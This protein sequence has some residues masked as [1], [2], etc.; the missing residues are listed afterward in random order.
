LNDNNENKNNNT[1][2]YTGDLVFDV[3]GD[4]ESSIKKN[5]L[6]TKWDRKRKKFVRTN[7]GVDINSHKA[8][9]MK[10]ESGATIKSKEPRGKLYADWKEKNK[11]EIPKQG[12]KE[13]VALTQ[14]IKENNPQ[15]NRRRKGI[16]HKQGQNKGEDKKPVKSELKTKEQIHKMR[17]QK[18]KLKLK[19]NPAL[20]RA[21]AKKKQERANNARMNFASPKGKNFSSKGK[22]PM[23]NKKMGRKK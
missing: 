13:D 12:E 8:K 2:M 15:W 21:I 17:K 22:K 10:N 4:D 16:W 5:N 7:A 11:I 20:R 19:Q 23:Q 18:E 9:K 14:R 3:A 6:V 1:A